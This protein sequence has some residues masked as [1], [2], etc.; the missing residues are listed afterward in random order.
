[1]N[2]DLRNGNSRSD[3]NDFGVESAIHYIFSGMW[4][5][6]QERYRLRISRYARVRIHLLYNQMSRTMVKIRLKN[7]S[8]L[9]RPVNKK[10]ICSGCGARQE[11]QTDFLF[12]GFAPAQDFNKEV[13]CKKKDTNIL[14]TEMK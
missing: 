14:S 2:L 4:I 6:P 7:K 12:Y 8:G 10:D 5:C 9:R 13:T 11:L 1:M 3:V